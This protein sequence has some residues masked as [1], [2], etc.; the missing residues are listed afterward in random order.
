MLFHTERA[1]ARQS[2]KSPDPPTCEKEWT[3][4]RTARNLPPDPLQMI[5]RLALFAALFA[6]LLGAESQAQRKQP[7]VGSAPPQP[8]ALAVK[9]RRDGRTEIPL[10]IYGRANEPLKYLIRT[11]PTH[12]RLS[13]PRPTE[14]EAAVAIYEPPA[15][16][17]ITTDKFL[18]AVQGT[19]GVSAAVEVTITITDQPPQLVIPD[20][21]EFPATRAGQAKAGLLE[22]SNKG[23]L[24][25]TGEVIVEAPW[26]IDGPATYKLPAGGIAVFKITFAPTT[27][28]SFDGVAR[29]TSDPEHS[30]TL[31]GSAETA[32]TATPSEVTLR[33]EPGDPVRTGEFELANQTDEPRTLQLKADERLQIP[34]QL[35]VPP[36]GKI[37]VPIQ[38]KPSDRHALATEIRLEAPD[39]A[40]TVPVKAPALSAV[41]RATPS[42]LTFGP[43]R[44]GQPASLRF[45]LENIGGTA[46]EVAW[47]IGAPFRVAQDSA[48]LVP[49][50]K[51]AFAVE[52][53]TGKPGK[54]RAWLQFKAGMQSFDLP[55]NAEVQAPARSGNGP[56]RVTD[57][58]TSSTTPET[59][60]SPSPDIPANEITPAVS[61]DWLADLTLPAGVKVTQITPTSALLE[62]PASLSPATSF[63]FEMRQLATD[64][65]GNLQVTWLAPTGVPIELR[66]QNYVAVMTGLQPGQFWTVR[67]RPLNASGEP[68][69]RLFA[70][71]FKTPLKPSPL[72][73]FSPLRGLLV[74]LLGLVAW[75]AWRRWHWKR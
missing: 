25:A 61:P 49:G 11:P 48:I 62:W 40:L 53:D 34:P 67:I 66:G 33:Q 39:F 65:G 24:V 9:V 15:D 19:V 64:A 29:F 16:L 60:T 41:I 14:R 58:A 45:E 18:Y 28:G 69:E 52:L 31:L 68:G 4:P 75:Q 56:A 71:D 38:T 8:L 21:L 12:G 59:P 30:T 7:P 23:G 51:R 13:E 17:A 5:P 10:R 63:R 26:R 2:H 44:I 46:G 32:I 70:V 47:Q 50:E 73:A 22:I 55:M 1:A 57:Q 3:R 72:S 42:T 27:G 43:L 74:A 54:Y 36:H 20:R 35:T 37:T 6:T